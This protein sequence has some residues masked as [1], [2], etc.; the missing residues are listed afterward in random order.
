MAR[1]HASLIP[2]SRQHQH[3][4][5]LAVIIRRRFGIEKGESAWLERIVARIRK[6]YSAELVSHFEVEETV[7]FPEM[8]RHLGRLE[9]T[10]ELLDEHQKLHGLVMRLQ[11]NPSLPTLDGLSLLLEGHIRK[12]ER[13]LFPEFEK[14]M[15]ADEAF[16]IGR[17]IHARLTTARSQL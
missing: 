3:A 14:R 8:E 9:L 5:G 17:E 13:Q 1:R 2:L 12:E 4:L 15:P 6:A 16:R 7:L 11:A 10:A